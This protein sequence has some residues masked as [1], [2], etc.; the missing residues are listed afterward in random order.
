[1]RPFRTGWIPAIFLFYPS[2]IYL[3]L[4]KV[5]KK[6]DVSQSKWLLG[7]LLLLCLLFDPTRILPRLVFLLLLLNRFFRHI[8]LS[9]VEPLKETMEIKML[10]IFG[11]KGQFSNN[12]LNVLFLQRQFSKHIDHILLGNSLLPILYIFECQ[13]QLLRIWADHLRNPNYHLL[14]FLLFHQREG[15]HHFPQLSNQNFI[16]KSLLFVYGLLLVA[17]I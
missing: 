15:I 11:T 16:V 10:Q 14:L 12:K 8:L 3:Y 4:S 9:N 6:K 1:M 7:I 17:I 13:L 5:T 2:V